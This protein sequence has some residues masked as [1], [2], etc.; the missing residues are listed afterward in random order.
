LT[1]SKTDEKLIDKN[2]LTFVAIH[3]LAHTMT[4]S[5]GHKEEFWSNFKFLLENAVRAHIYIATDYAKNPI[6]YCG[7]LIDESPLYKK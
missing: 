2:T 4:L 7:I 3:E 6:Q 5:I 1:K